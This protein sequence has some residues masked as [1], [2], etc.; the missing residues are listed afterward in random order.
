MTRPV[1]AYLP[2]V[3]EADAEGRVAELYADIRRVLGLPLVNLVYRHLA[4]EPGRLESTWRSLRPNLASRGADEA[5]RLLAAAAAPPPVEP[6]AAAALARAGLAGDRAALARATLDTYARGNSRNL[7]GMWALLDGCAG[8]GPGAE[9][10]DPPPPEPILPMADLAAL[11][12]PTRELLEELSRPL[13]GGGPPVLVPSLL[14]H[15][16][17]PPLLALVRE[18]LGPAAGGRSARRAAVSETARGLAAALPHPVAPL[19]EGAGRDVAAR[20]AGTISA[21][22]VA[23][24]TLRAAFAAAG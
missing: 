5:A 1:P 13:V 2:E 23:G 6:L 18:A 14:R 16:A 22:L 24:E 11:D 12:R 9:P 20:F 15:F 3:A 10:L 8:G 7:L 19:A 4:V 17:E 21:L